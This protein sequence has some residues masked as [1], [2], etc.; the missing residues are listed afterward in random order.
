[1]RLNI[2][3]TRCYC[4]TWQ[5]NFNVAFKRSFYQPF[6]G[7]LTDFTPLDV[8]HVTEGLECMRSRDRGEQMRRVY[9]QA[10]TTST[11]H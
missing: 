1:M 11:L 2:F 5:S 4:R 10:I 9:Q 3:T 7:C 8:S 6:L